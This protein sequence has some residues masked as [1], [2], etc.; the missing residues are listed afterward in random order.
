VDQCRGL[1][2]LAGFLLSELLCGQLAQLVI[3]EGQKLLGGVRIALVNRVQDLGQV[4]HESEHNARECDSQHSNV[5]R[6]QLYQHSAGVRGGFFP[7]TRR[8]D[9]SGGLAWSVGERLQKAGEGVLGIP[10]EAIAVGAGIAAVL[11]VLVLVLG[12]KKRP[13]MNDEDDPFK[14]V[15]AGGPDHDPFTHGS[16]SEKRRALR[17]RGRSVRVLVSDE[18]K[19]AVP[20]EGW[21]VDRSLTGLCLAV[22]ESIPVGLVVSVC[23]A[24]VNPRVWVHVRVRNCHKRTSDVAV[25]C[26]F[27]SPLPSDV[28]WPFG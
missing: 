12:L 9:H 8:A 5:R 2:R 4:G 25:G 14:R 23:V 10:V 3:D 17:R 11:I 20:Y 26:E 27:V 1:E 13:P 21:V 22:R 7:A 28:L 18:Q 6:T 19:R 24:D 15:L 16:A